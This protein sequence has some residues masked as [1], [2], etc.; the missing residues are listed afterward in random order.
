MAIEIKEYVGFK[1][2]AK[3]IKETK[4]K[5]TIKRNAPKVKKATKIKK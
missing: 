3:D 5:R 4:K 2:E 1:T